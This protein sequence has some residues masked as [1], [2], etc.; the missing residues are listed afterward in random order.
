MEPFTF[1]RKILNRFNTSFPLQ[2][3]A[4]YGQVIGPSFK[5]LSFLSIYTG[6]PQNGFANIDSCAKTFLVKLLGNGVSHCQPSSSS[7]VLKA[8]SNISKVDDLNR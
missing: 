4:E 1:C 2:E 5:R 6:R 3:D 8:L 7:N